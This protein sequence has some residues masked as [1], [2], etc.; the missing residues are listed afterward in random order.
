M[1]YYIIRRV[2]A[3][4]IMIAVISVVVFAL[5]YAM[6]ANPARLSCGKTC[7]E[8]QVQANRH[9]L[10]YDKPLVTQYSE[11]MQGIFQGRKF[12]DDKAFQ[13]RNPDK[14]T[15][16]PAP[17][18]GYSPSRTSLVSSY[19]AQRWPVSV[20]I[21][22]GAFVIWLG[23]GVGFGI[24]AALTRGKFLDR[25]LVTSSLIVYSFPTFFLGLIIY[26]YASIQYSILPA[27][28]YV[29]FFQSPVDWAKGLIMAWIVLA[30]VYAAAYIRLTR[31]YML[32]T[33]G[34]DY[35]RTARAKG[36]G[37][38]S[39]IFKHTLRA[40]LTPIVTVAG[41]DL[42]V[43]LAGTVIMEQ[44]LNY[45]GLG[46]AAVDATT[47]FDLPMIVGI[48]LVSSTLIVVANLVVDVL[49]GVIDP[50]VRLT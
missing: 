37:T 49:Y 2:I 43:V 34:E 14:V 6:P 42:G 46:R 18:L 15:N 24:I 33:M 20:S 47:Q 32:E 45:Q 3:A 36:V 21:A 10:G 12:P 28:N 31:S 4:I 22:I 27:P 5:F 35:L 1:I 41:L 23:V 44:V 50:R 16:C 40:A 26:T 9:Y 19:I 25:L 17:C 11:F 39:I 48:V 7:T 29:S 13:E 38:R 8:A 30:A